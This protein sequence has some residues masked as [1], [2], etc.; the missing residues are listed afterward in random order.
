MTNTIEATASSLKLSYL[1]FVSD[2]APGLSLVLALVVMDSYGFLEVSI[3]PHDT[4]DKAVVAILVI[5][6]ATPVGLVINGASHFLLGGTERWID[7]RCFATTIWPV[8]DTKRVLR[9]DEWT[10]FF[11]ITNASDWPLVAQEI[12][13]ILDTLLPHLAAL[14]DHVRALKKFCRSVAF[15]AIVAAFVA[16]GEWGAVA[17]AGVIGGMAILSITSS[18]RWRDTAIAIVRLSFAAVLILCGIKSLSLTVALV[19]VGSSFVL[20]G[21][22][23]DFYQHGLTMLFIYQLLVHDGSSFRI[24][25]AQVRKRLLVFLRSAKL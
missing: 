10:R 20:L 16:V 24:T 6:L 7:Q 21:G 17:A 1:R 3:I 23:V 18:S 19:L 8:V 12:D 22:L 11:Q 15:L 5:L 2:S 4:T 25:P 14:L 13:E 9:F